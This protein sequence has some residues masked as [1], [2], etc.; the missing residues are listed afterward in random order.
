MEK[1]Y[2]ITLMSNLFNNFLASNKIKKIQ[3]Y[4]SLKLIQKS[5]IK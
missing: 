3:L 1:K 5:L 2:I 4:S